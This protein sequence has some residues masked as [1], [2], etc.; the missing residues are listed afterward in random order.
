[1]LSNFT[2]SVSAFLFPSGWL[3]H[4]VPQVATP[5]EN[6]HA[7]AIELLNLAVGAN[8]SCSQAWY[9]LGRCH[10]DQGNFKNAFLAYRQSVSKSE[11]QSDTWCAIG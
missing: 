9:F 4:T 6:P 7:K 3:Y 2:V 11:N 1:M 8:P 10:A 5:G